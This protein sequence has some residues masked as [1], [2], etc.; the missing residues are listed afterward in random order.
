[1]LAERAPTI[2]DVVRRIVDVVPSTQFVKFLPGAV[3]PLASAALAIADAIFK[4]I[5]Q[6]TL[7]LDLK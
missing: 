1:M 4:V 5:A 6:Q 2:R 7:M 3:Q